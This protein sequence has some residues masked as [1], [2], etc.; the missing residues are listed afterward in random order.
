MPT[1]SQ[2]Q[3][4]SVRC[5]SGRAGTVTH[6]N[7]ALLFPGT[8]DSI[9]MTKLY[10]TEVFVPTALL[11]QAKTVQFQKLAWTRHAQFELVHDQ[12]GMIPA[13]AVPL[14]FDGRCWELIELE[15]DG[16]QVTKYVFRRPVDAWRSL[17][18]V[19]RPGVRQPDRPWAAYVVTAWTNRTGDKHKTL[20]RSKYATA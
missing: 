4:Y 5:S 10:H 7:T 19:L 14:S 12:H 15:A 18:I 1:K 16:E 3:I 17:V 8:A 20:D 2:A 13:T 9:S 6:K 11:N